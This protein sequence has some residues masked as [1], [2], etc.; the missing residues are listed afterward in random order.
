MKKK[1][2]LRNVAKMIV[3]CLAVAALFISCE[4]DD[5]GNGKLGGKQSPIGKE[6]NSFSFVGGVPGISSAFGSVTALDDGVSTVT[7]SVNITNSNYLNMLSNAFNTGILTGGGI[8]G[9]T[10]SGDL[11]YRFTDEGIQSICPDGT[12]HTAVKYN[13]KVGDVYTLKQGSRTI[14]REVTVVSKKDEFLWNNMKIKTI[15]VKETG[16][17]VPGINYTE[18]VY[19]HKFA[20]VAVKFGFEDGTTQTLYLKSGV[21][22]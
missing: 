1:L 20:L 13:A 17:G 19:N 7:V 22:N 5:S 14:R 3:A 4:K 10:V 21:T 8:T 11:R 15:H 9:T 16:R 2:N 12:A 18:N 6:G